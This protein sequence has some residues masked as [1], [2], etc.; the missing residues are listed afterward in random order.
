ML[1]SLLLA[2]CF[3]A[4]SLHADSVPTQIAL[5]PTASVP[6]ADATA[7]SPGGVMAPYYQALNSGQIDAAVSYLDLSFTSDG[8]MPGKLRSRDAF[9]HELTILYSAFSDAHVDV[10]ETLSQGNQVAVR[11]VF[12]GTWSKNFHGMEPKSPKRSVKVYGIDLWDME[13]GKAVA[14]H[15][16]MDALSLL[17]QMG[18]IPKLQ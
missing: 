8:S 17:V 3:L 1:R 7:S 5:S 13:G 16:S 6:S 9:A 4:L 15:G 11:F 14:L 12:S 10:L 2:S 18:L